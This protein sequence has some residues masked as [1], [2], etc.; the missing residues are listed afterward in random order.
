LVRKI[1]GLFDREG[2]LV[3]KVIWSGRLFGR[4]YLFGRED[5]LVGIVGRLFDREGYLYIIWSGRL[6][7]REVICV[8]RLFV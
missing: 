1:G 5:C 3:G 8:G 6:F 4:E 7:G 2:Y